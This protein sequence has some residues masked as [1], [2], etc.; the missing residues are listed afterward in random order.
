SDATHS[1]G[2]RVWPHLDPGRG[3]AARPG[4][5]AGR[6]A[7][8]RHAGLAR[9]RI[10]HDAELSGPYSA[11][12]LLRLSKFAQTPLSPSQEPL[13]APLEYSVARCSK[14]LACSTPFRISTNQGSGW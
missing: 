3:D 4:L 2:V 11:A 13:V 12:R 7:G 1:C 6:R 10:P 5:Y 9:S 14:K 8:R